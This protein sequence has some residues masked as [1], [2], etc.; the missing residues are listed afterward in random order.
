MPN[1]IV[2][3][4]IDIEADSPEDAALAAVA[5]QRHRDSTAV[6]FEITDTASGHRTTVDLERED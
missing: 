4:R 3:W 1:Y 5:V 2:I 6:V